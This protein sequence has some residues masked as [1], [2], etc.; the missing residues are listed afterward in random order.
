MEYLFFA[1]I[2]FILGVFTGNS[3]KKYKVNSG[4]ALLLNIMKSEFKGEEYHILNSITLPIDDGTT[5][6]DHIVISTKGI[7][8]IETKNYSGWIFGKE[9]DKKWTQ[10]IYK[11]KTRFQNPIRQNYKHVVAVRKLLEFLPKE[12][13]FSV[14]VFVGDAEF[15]TNIPNGVLTTKQFIRYI[16]NINDK[17]MTKN[18][19]AFSVGKIE[20]ARYHLSKKTDIDHQNYLTKKFGGSA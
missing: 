15:K 14:V 8:V 10:V 19:L 5:Q 2:I 3:I 4:E 13:V 16:A 18:D 17:P 12:N 9:N 7:F 20:C 1:L 6:I 11:K